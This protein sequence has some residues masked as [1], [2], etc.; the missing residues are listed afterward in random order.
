MQL[1]YDRINNALERVSDTARRR[2]RVVINVVNEEELLMHDYSNVKNRPVP[3][4]KVSIDRVSC[5]FQLFN[6]NTLNQTKRKEEN[7]NN[8]VKRR[9]I[10]FQSPVS[11]SCWYK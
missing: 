7:S 5:V 8:V 4:K 6:G 9:L 2:F 10:H 11:I 1:S 3:K